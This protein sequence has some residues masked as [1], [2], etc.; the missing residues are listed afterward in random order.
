MDVREVEK[1]IGY[2]FRDE[3]LLTRA[4]TLPSYGEDNYQRLEFFGDAILEYIVSERLFFENLPSEGKMTDKRK[5]IVSDRALRE[6]S[7]KLGLYK[8][9]LKGAGDV[10]N[11]KAVPSVYE[12]LVA[13]IYLDGGMDEAKR[14]VA[15]TL[16]FS[17]KAFSRNFKGELQEYLQS[18]A[19]PCPE[20][21]R[22]QIGTIVAPRFSASVYVA[23]LDA[24]FTGEG[25]SAREA[26]QN[27]A[28][29]AMEKI[30]KDSK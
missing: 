6:A 14:F 12:S 9:V 30:R 23:P 20:Y 7:E 11:K 1:N 25:D 8:N 28:R 27:A 22:E 24:T 10:G 5:A 21:T 29:A 18:L 19:Y 26:E 15:S 16:D 3:S 2:T 4:L 13:A 17:G